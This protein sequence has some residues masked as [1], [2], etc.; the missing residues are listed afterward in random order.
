[1]QCVGAALRHDVDRPAGRTAALDRP[2]VRDDL[3]L[4]DEFERE[5]RAG[6]AGELVVVVQSVDRQ[7][8]AARAQPAETE[9][10]ILESRR[11]ATACRLAVGAGHTWREQHEFQIVPAADGQLLDTLHVDRRSS[12]TSAANR[13]PAAER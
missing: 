11:H 2:P 7:R 13:A 8:V 10:A 5:L 1:M 9:S 12:P 3:E 6:G 4:S